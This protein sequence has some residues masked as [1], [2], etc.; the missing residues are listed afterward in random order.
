[1][2]P[3]ISVDAFKSAIF[4]QYPPCMHDDMIWHDACTQNSEPNVMG[5]AIRT[6]GYRYIEWV[7]FDKNTSTPF[8]TP[9]LANELYEHEPDPQSVS[10][11]IPDEITNLA[12]NP[13][14]ADTIATLSAKLHAG[15][16][17]V[18]PPV[19]LDVQNN[20]FMSDF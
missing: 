17:A 15:W 7:N 12:N 5:Y 18:S 13:Q 19:K 11:Q 8:W 10:T 16:R 1:M 4:H 3:N 2:N 6:N 14:Y 9:L 20:L